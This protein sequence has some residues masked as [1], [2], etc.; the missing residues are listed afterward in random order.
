M[1][2][3]GLFRASR[4]VRGLYCLDLSR[5]RKEPDGRASCRPGVTFFIQPTCQAERCRRAVQRQLAST[6]ADL[7]AA[8]LKEQGWTG[9]RV[10]TFA[11]HVCS[12]MNQEGTKKCEGGCLNRT[13]H[14][15]DECRAKDRREHERTTGCRGMASDGWPLLPGTPGFTP[16]QE[17]KCLDELMDAVMGMMG[18]DAGALRRAGMI[19]SFVDRQRRGEGRGGE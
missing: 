15:G 8:E 14:C 2:L 6:V 19:G 13:F 16:E 5:P 9:W 18:H 1:R 4:H 11:Y 3:G 12:G 7:R 17:A 10:A